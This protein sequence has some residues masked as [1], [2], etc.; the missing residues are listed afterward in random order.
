MGTAAVDGP[1]GAET[2][3]AALALEEGLRNEG[4]REGAGEL[5]HRRYPDP[6]TTAVGSTSTLPALPST[7]PATAVMTAAHPTRPAPYATATQGERVLDRPS[8]P[9]GAGRPWRGRPVSPDSYVANDGE[10]R[11]IDAAHFCAA[12]TLLWYGDGGGEPWMLLA[13]E[14]R[15]GAAGAMKNFLGGKRES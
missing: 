15:G 13:V 10:L 11:E 2:Y 8:L 3:G 9:G 5:Q 12:G 14:E 7:F 6:G 1:V 4:R